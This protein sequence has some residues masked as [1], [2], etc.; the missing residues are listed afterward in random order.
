MS[1]LFLLAAAFAFVD[2]SPQSVRL[3][4]NGEPVYVYNHGV[5][6]GDD[7][8]PRYAR[9]CYVHP[10][11]APDGTVVTDDFPRDHFHH[12]GLSWMWPVVIV[13]GEEHDLWALRGIRHRFVQW[14]AR[15]AR[16]DRALLRVR[17]G[18]FTERRKVVTETVEIVALPGG[19]LEL[20]LTFEAEGRPVA[21]QGTHDH[22]KGYGGLGLRFAPR[23]DTVL[24]T[25]QGVEMKD[26]D[27]RAHAWAE[28]EGTFENGSGA[29]ARIDIDASSPGFPSGWCLRRYGYLGANYPGLQR[30]TI[31][32]GNPLVLRYRVRAYNRSPAR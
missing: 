8:P 23:K 29:G 21:I 26:S 18:W 24:R 32:P 25:D 22:N 10:L 5:M 16:R 6:A 19:Q 1:C 27:M 9:C 11:Y 20:K 15:E 7:A 31:E 17:N 12:R 13:D 4:E 2:I 28:L 14:L 30:H 3:E